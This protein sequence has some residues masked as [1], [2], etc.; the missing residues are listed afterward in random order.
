LRIEGIE[1]PDEYKYFNE[2]DLNKFLN[3][4]LEIEE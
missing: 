3:Y 4:D 2:S 1:F